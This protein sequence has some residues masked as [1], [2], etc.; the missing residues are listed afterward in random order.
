MT[1]RNVQILKRSIGIS[2]NKINN[3]KYKN[4]TI[5]DDLICFHA[6]ETNSKHQHKEINQQKNI[7]FMRRKSNG[8][9]CC[10]KKTN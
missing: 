1:K 10:K 2:K 4:K 9:L 6:G 7:G 5:V 3:K 8:G